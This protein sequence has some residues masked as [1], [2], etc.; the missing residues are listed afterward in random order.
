[1]KV[2]GSQAGW[3]IWLGWIAASTVGMFVGFIAS[4]FAIVFI[5]MLTELVPGLGDVDWLGDLVF[6]IGLGV[7]VGVLQWVVLWIFLELQSVG[8]GAGE[9]KWSVLWQQVSRAGWWVLAS[10]A[11]CYGIINSGFIFISEPFRFDPLRIIGVVALGGAVAGIL[12]WLVLRGKVSRAGWWVLA[13]TVGWALGVTVAGAIPW[14]GDAELLQLVMVA[15]VMGVVTG[16]ALVWLLR[17]P[18]PEAQLE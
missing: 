8:I 11:A 9:L 17:H 10:V 2:K 4:F 14:G 3:G 15:A 18:V 6:G 13:S 5:A 16:G 7:G 12:Q 1:M